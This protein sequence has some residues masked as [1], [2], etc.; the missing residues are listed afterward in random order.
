MRCC[1]R[2]VAMT[3]VT[4]APRVSQPRLLPGEMGKS[5]R[6]VRLGLSCII[7]GWKKGGLKLKKRKILGEELMALSWLKAH[8]TDLDL[9]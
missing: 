8:V 9:E 4:E 3:V 2:K 5:R 1:S 6:R 7:G